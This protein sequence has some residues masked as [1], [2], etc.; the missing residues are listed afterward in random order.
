MCDNPN[1]LTNLIPKKTDF[2]FGI[3]TFADCMTSNSNQTKDSF[4]TNQFTNTTS[5][6]KSPFPST[7]VSE[8]DSTTI[9][10]DQNSF[11]KSQL[12]QLRAQ[13]IAYRALD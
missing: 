1:E 4:G 5:S 2:L 7:E 11:Q 6:V 9:Q 3:N 8:D 10:P 12:V 13:I